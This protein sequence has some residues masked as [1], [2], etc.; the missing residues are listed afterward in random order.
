MS[1]GGRCLSIGRRLEDRKVFIA[2]M[3]LPA[4][5]IRLTIRGSSSV[6]LVLVVIAVRSVCACSGKALFRV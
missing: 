5:S 2:C 3:L 1:S 4:L 6:S